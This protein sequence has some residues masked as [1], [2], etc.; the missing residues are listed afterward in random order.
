MSDLIKFVTDFIARDMK[1]RHCIY[2]GILKALY[3]VSMVVYVFAQDTILVLVGVLSLLT[4]C[5]FLIDLGISIKNKKTKKKFIIYTSLFAAQIAAI[6]LI[7][8]ITGISTTNT[9]LTSIG[10]IVIF[11]TIVVMFFDIAKS[12]RDTHR[13]IADLLHH[14]NLCII[15]IIVILVIISFAVL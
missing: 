4:L 5:A 14:I 7:S 13:A 10:F 11:A 9:L 3:I 8:I 2:I 6:H 12:I 15:L 1:E